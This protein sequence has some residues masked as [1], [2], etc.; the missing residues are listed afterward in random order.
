MMR[1]FFILIFSWSTNLLAIGFEDAA[2]PEL[3][4]SAR[5]LAL[6]NAFISRVNDNSAPFYNPAGTGVCEKV[7]LSVIKCLC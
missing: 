5:A 4:P 6:G 7:I 3:M 2:R 1:L